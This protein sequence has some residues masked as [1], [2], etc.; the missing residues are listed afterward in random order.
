[1]CGSTFRAPPRPSSGACNCISNLWFYRWS[2]AVAALLLAALLVAA[3]L[4]AAF[5]VVVGLAGR[6]VGRPARPRQ[7]TLL[8]TTIEF[9]LYDHA[10][11]CQR[12]TH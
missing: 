3:L 4:V 7:T 11:T 9:E 5:L 12:Q 10:R 1:M 2:V 6:P 8:P